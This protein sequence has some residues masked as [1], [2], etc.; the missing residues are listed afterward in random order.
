MEGPKTRREGTFLKYSLGCMQQ[1]GVK[2]EMGGRAPLAPRWR[3][4]SIAL[5]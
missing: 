3:R 4:P 5:L 1:P 2:R